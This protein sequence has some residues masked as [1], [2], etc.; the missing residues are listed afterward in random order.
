VQSF[1]I[2][3]TVQTIYGTYRDYAFALTIQ[4]AGP[5]SELFN[6]T[7][8]IYEWTML[9]YTQ[10]LSHWALNEYVTGFAYRNASVLLQTGI[11]RITTRCRD[12]QHMSRNIFIQSLQS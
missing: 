12:A 10:T 7:Y 2:T 6:V 1:A 5:E 11:S 3:F 4:I 9:S 8:N